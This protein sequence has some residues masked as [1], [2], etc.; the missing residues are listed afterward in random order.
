MGTVAHR[1]TR[2]R[3]QKPLQLTHRTTEA[4]CLVYNLVHRRGMYPNITT[5]SKDVANLMKNLNDV[6]TTMSTGAIPAD[7]EVSSMIQSSADDS[8]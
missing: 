3:R 2:T 5:P 6:L 1:Q 4:G 7:G 8:E